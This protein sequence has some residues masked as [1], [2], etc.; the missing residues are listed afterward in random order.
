MADSSPVLQCRGDIFAKRLGAC[1]RR[2]AMKLKFSDLW[3]TEGTI[4]RAQYAVLG[5]TLLILKHNLDRFVAWKFFGKPWSIFSYVIPRT[6]AFSEA[7]RP[8][9]LTILLY[10]MPFM[11][12][13]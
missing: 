7:D 4:G 12:S 10:S 1:D 13:G 3:R 6:G 8:L 11:W 9:Y 5:A 2:R